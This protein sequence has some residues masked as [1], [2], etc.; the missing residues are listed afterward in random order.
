[1]VKIN[2][3]KLILS[4]IAVIFMASLCAQVNK[5]DVIVAEYAGKQITLAD[6]EQRIAEIPPMQQSRF[7]NNEGK[8]DL[9]KNMCTEELFYEEAKAL[10]MEK[11]EEVISRTD[12][13]VKTFYSQEYKKSISERDMTFTEEEKKAYFHENKDTIFGGRTYPEAEKEIEMRLR[14]QKVKLLTE[15]LIKALSDK[16]KIVM[17]EDLIKTVNLENIEANKE[18]EN[19]KYLT[20]DVPELERDIAYIVNIFKYLPAQTQKSIT[21][22]DKLVEMMK[23]H[24][25]MD[26]LY[27][28]AM[29]EGLDKRED[30]A[31]K[32]QQIRR[33]VLLRTT[34]NKLIVEPIPQDDESA[35]TYYEDN[36]E[37][38]SSNSHRKIQTF[39]F[40]TKEKAEELYPIIKK[41]AKTKDADAEIAE[42]VQLN[43]L[44]KKDDGVVDFIYANGIIPNRG[45][46]QYYN[47]LIFATPDKKVKAKKLSELFE[48]GDGDWAFFRILEVTP[49]IAEPFVEIM[50]KVKNTMLRELSRENFMAKETELAAKYNLVKYNDRL[51]VKLT[52][53]EY[54]TKAEEAQKARR[55]ND[56]VYYYDKLIEYFPGTNH[57]YKASFMKAFLYSEELKDKRKATELFEDF[58]KNFDKGDLH[59]SAKFMLGELNGDSKLI[60][61]FEDKE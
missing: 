19:E 56:A 6:V 39:E 40:K 30:L 5:A 14:P 43:S 2:P 8:I 45:K 55:Y 41:L 25:E 29:E 31:A 50:P 34:Y 51:I 48:T 13:Q 22:T 9:L 26:L 18:I 37:K 23:S 59:E 20:S 44:R 36:I 1:M 16:Y 32:E 21:D 15:S 49:A 17:N 12:P 4:I 24:L 33:L 54:F 27:G 61:K 52:P 57:E 60:E 7:T 58:L 47:D 10:G 28:K 11:T 35:Q 53:E 3:S 46:D 42:I 38:F